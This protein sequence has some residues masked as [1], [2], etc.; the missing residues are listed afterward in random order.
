M[1][2]KNFRKRGFVGGN[3]VIATTYF[4]LVL[5]HGDDS[6]SAL[7]FPLDRVTSKLAEIEVLREE[8]R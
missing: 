8:A 6:L 1:T 7:A 5:G 2:V 3:R 4:S